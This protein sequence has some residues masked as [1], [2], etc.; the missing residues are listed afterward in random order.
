MGAGSLFDDKTDNITRVGVFAVVAL[1][2]FAGW[3]AMHPHTH[4]QAEGL[5]FA[6]DQGVQESKMTHTPAV[7][8]VTAGWCPTCRALHENVLSRSDVRNELNGHYTF[9]KLDMTDP[10]EKQGQLL[11]KISVNCYP[12][13]IRF[14]RDG[15]ETARANY[16]PPDQMI[17]WLQAGE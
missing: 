15:N 10:T 8:L 17:A 13:L 9:V 1:L 11:G 2:A 14:D 3:R 6:Y 12:T 7:V 5:D 16:L 4:F